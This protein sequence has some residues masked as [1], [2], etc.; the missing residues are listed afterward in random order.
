VLAAALSS[1]C[2]YWRTQA[3]YS[4]AGLRGFA[5]AVTARGGPVWLGAF[6]SSK[7]YLR[8]IGAL[9]FS[10]KMPRSVEEGAFGFNKTGHIRRIRALLSL[11]TCQWLALT[12]FLEPK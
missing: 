7:T 12:S 2:F 9:S 1:Q 8:L 3:K 11:Q 10:K 6:V 4:E 5:H